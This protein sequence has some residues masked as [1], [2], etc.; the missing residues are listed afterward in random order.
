MWLKLEV[1]SSNFNGA[2]FHSMLF[3]FF[4][5]LYSFH[6]YRRLFRCD[7]TERSLAPAVN[8]FRM[9]VTCENQWRFDIN[10]VVL[11]SY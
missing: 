9:V 10:D 3:L 8:V 2:T 5:H 4:F 6:L 7:N 1:N 11:T